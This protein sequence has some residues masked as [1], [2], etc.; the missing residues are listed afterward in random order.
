MQLQPHEVFNGCNDNG[1]LSTHEKSSDSNSSF[2]SDVKV[3][4]DDSRVEV[5]LR[6]QQNMMWRFAAYGQQPQDTLNGRMDCGLLY[7]H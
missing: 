7:T 1:L 2:C 5:M 4:L 6:Q 3:C